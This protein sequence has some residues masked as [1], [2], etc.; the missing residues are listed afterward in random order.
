VKAKTVVISVLLGAFC[1][2]SWA[3][4]SYYPNQ[5]KRDD[6]NDA[7][8]DRHYSGHPIEQPSPSRATTAGQTQNEDEVHDAWLDR[9]YSGQPVESMAMIQPAAEKTVGVSPKP[10]T[11]PV[12]APAAKANPLPQ[13]TTPPVPVT[14]EKATPTAV[15]R[16]DSADSTATVN[17][18]DRDEDVPVASERKERSGNLPAAMDQG[19]AD[20]EEGLSELKGYTAEVASNV[21]KKGLRGFLDVSPEAKAKGRSI[22]EKIGQGIRGVMGEVGKEMAE[23]GAMH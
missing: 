17:N 3:V 15:V 22:G 1:S 13:A 12:V 23:E 19:V 20:M 2:S 5:Q 10:V 7:W 21:R 9:H 8:L 6:A 4:Q 18:G 11:V 14:E 16:D